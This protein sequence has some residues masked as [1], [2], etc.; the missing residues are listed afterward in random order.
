MAMPASMQDSAPKLVDFTPFE[1]MR[2]EYEAMSIY[3]SGHLMEFVHPKLPRD[4]FACA[5]AES[6]PEGKAIRVAG[7]P[8]ARQ[9]PKGRAARCSSR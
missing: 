1:K 5:A 2:G 9:H 4:V 7:W 3:P 8:V 6:T